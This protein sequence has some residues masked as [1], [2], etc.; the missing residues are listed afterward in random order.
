MAEH[1]GATGVRRSHT[2]SAPSRASAIRSRAL[3]R[4]NWRT[5]ARS[6]QPV[7]DERDGESGA[8]SPGE[9]SD[10]MPLYS[11]AEAGLSRHASMPTQRDTRLS[12]SQYRPTES[13]VQ[14]PVEAPD[15]YRSMR[16]DWRDSTSPVR[17]SACS[18]C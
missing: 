13:P 17:R 5:Q 9:A 11:L 10:S 15:A 6:A 14:S 1:G 16:S 18:R 2:T 4:I 3:D 7:D 12:R 8:T